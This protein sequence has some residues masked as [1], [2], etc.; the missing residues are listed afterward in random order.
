MVVTFK[1]NIDNYIHTT[2]IYVNKSKFGDTIDDNTWI[3]DGYR[4]HDLI[5]LNLHKYC[6]ISYVYNTLNGVET[7]KT[8]AKLEETLV[9]LIFNLNVVT[10]DT[11]LVE[12]IKNILTLMNKTEQLEYILYN[13]SFWFSQIKHLNDSKKDLEII[14]I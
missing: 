7:S 14:H 6:G 11:I 12:T 8:L 1:L 3:D 5:H 2:D 13:S 9:L 10:N 4:F